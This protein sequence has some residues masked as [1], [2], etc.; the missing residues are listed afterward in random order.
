MPRHL[1]V[2]ILASLAAAAGIGA[3]HRSIPSILD[4]SLQ[5]RE[6][7]IVKKLGPSEHLSAG[8][9]YRTLDYLLAPEERSDED[10]DWT[11]YFEKPSG[12]IVSVT[13]NFAKPTQVTELF[14]G[15]QVRSHKFQSGPGAPLPALSRVLPG[16]RVLVAIG[17][18]KSGDACSQLV[19]MRRT[20]LARFYPWIAKGLE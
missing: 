13:R 10:Y 20:A 6:I 5:E 11:F 9:S 3:D 4:F 1:S 18:S 12:A 15:G 17:L 19:L 7:D 14:R 2:L 16:A 8:S